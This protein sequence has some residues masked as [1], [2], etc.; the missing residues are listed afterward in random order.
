MQ[1]NIAA[2]A[3]NILYGTIEL[4]RNF[5]ELHLVAVE[6]LMR[7]M[8]RKRR[9]WIDMVDSE[10]TDTRQRREDD[11]VLSTDMRS[12]L[13]GDGVR[14]AAVNALARDFKDLEEDI[15]NL[16]QMM[17][18]MGVSDPVLSTHYVNLMTSTRDVPYAVY[19]T[20]ADDWKTCQDLKPLI[21]LNE[22]D[23]TGS[24]GGVNVRH[25]PA[26]MVANIT[27]ATGITSA[28]Y[29][30]SYEL[31]LRSFHLMLRKHF[32]PNYAVDDCLVKKMGKLMVDVNDSVKFSEL[33]SE[34][35]NRMDS[36]EKRAVSVRLHASS[37]TAVDEDS[38]IS[39]D[40]TAP[41]L[42]LPSV[43]IGPVG[44]RTSAP[45]FYSSRTL[46][47]KTSTKKLQ[48]LRKTPLRRGTLVNA[49]GQLL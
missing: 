5:A 29:K 28:N 15:E 37:E 20:L 9:P 21:V 39:D 2:M 43:P 8:N 7:L 42:S 4:I 34:S 49:D 18:D 38:S 32:V 47:L 36:M 25:V 26:H 31:A 17:T 33:T 3:I 30:N 1:S 46:P 22:R 12:M 11:Y 24:N 6:D 45:S 48:P 19:K 16:L 10:S 14:G 40:D 44:G 23:S 41:H 27:G 13:F 35:M